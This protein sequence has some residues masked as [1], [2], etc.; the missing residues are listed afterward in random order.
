MIES[1]LEFMSSLPQSS[2]LSAILSPLD[3]FTKLLEAKVKCGKMGNKCTM[4]VQ[5]YTYSD[6]NVWEGS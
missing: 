3:V 6:K 4:L 1:R 5:I 2:I